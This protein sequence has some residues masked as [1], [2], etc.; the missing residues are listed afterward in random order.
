MSFQESNGGANVTLLKIH[1]LDQD[2]IDRLSQIGAKG[3]YLKQ[4][5]KDSLIEHKH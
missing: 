5:L 4:Q 1:A 2:T 3:I